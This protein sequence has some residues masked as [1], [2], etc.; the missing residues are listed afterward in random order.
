VCLTRV[1]VYILLWVFHDLVS[2]I[3]REIPLSILISELKSENR[4]MFKVII[5]T[6]ALTLKV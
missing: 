1:K 3:A 2:K 6:F 5:I 4:N